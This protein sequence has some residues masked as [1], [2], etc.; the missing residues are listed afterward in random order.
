MSVLRLRP[1]AV[2]ERIFPKI[3]RFGH[4]RSC[5]PKTHPTLA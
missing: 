1:A 2:I 4:G 5:N 3:G